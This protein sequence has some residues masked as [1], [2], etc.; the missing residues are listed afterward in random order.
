MDDVSPVTMPPRS[1]WMSPCWPPAVSFDQSAVSSVAISPNRVRLDNSEDLPDV[2]PVFEVSPDT[3]GFLMRPSGAAVQA[4][5]SCLPLL[6]GSASYCD[7]VLGDPVAFTVSG[8]IPGS[9]APPMT[10]P[11]YPLPSGLAL[12]PGQSWDGWS[13]GVPQTYDVSREGPF[14]AYCSPMDT[15]DSP[16]V[17]TG[18]PGSP[19]R[20]TSH[21][22]LEVADTNP[23]YGMQ[24]HHPRF[25]E[26]IRVPESAR[27]WVQRM[28]EEDA[29]AAAINL[30]RDAGVMLSNLQTLSQFVT[31][32]HRMSTEMLNLGWATWYSLHRRSR[33]CLRRRGRLGRHSIWPRWDYGFLRRVRAIPACAG[34]IL[35]CVHELS[36]LFPGGAGLFWGV[37]LYLLVL[38][39][40][41]SLVVH[42]RSPDFMNVCQSCY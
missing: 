37:T 10:F 40:Q 7:P 4:P 21:T 26:F 9:D 12:L 24:L 33:L 42:N 38:L 18:L 8:P 27:F 3:S 1:A 32:L 29:V 14:D 19:Y 22:G 41:Y 34:F 36:V 30:Q 6:P 25:L 17:A 35:Q 39:G 5:V 28:G 2:E 16:L 15:G 31:S 23:A 13:T 11:V 20:I